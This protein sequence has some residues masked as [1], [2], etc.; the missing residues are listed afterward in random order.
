[1]KNF[2]ILDH[3]RDGGS[4]DN[5]K[6]NDDWIGFDK[7]VAIVADGATGLSDKRLVNADDSDAQWIAK[8]AVEHFLGAR[9]EDPVRELVRE[10][11]LHATSIIFGNH[12][13]E[14]TPKYSWP[15]S[16]FI[17][18]RSQGG[19]IEL[20]GLGDCTAL[21]EMSDGFIDRFSAL[22]FNKSRESSEAARDLQQR[23]GSDGEAIRTPEVIASLRRK[24]EILNTA[25]SGVWTLGLVPEAADH[26]FT[27]ALPAGE[28]RSILL[29]SDGF[30][31]IVD[32]Y[33]HF[34]E[35]SL[36]EIAKSRGLLEINC[37][38]RKIER[39]MDPHAER[40]PRYKQSDDSSAILLELGK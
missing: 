5:T 3:I 8:L 36:F 31:A 34:D 6:A 16:S 12:P 11:N 23:S 4:P 19:V 2:N 24:R 38:I 20:S 27:V 33:G 26:V 1:M 39:E 22:P 32:G 30:S 18:A 37:E 29:M 9:A 13:K 7:R 17:M 14:T 40:F 25:Q 28:I 35:A 15:S 10:I 21:V